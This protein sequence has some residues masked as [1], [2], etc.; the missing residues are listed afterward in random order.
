MLIMSCPVPSVVKPPYRASPVTPPDISFL[1]FFTFW[2]PVYYHIDS[3]E[4]TYAYPPSSSEHSA[5]WVSLSTGIGD[6]F[7]WQ[8]LNDLTQKEHDVHH[9]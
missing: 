1:L 6:Q 7:T 8:I 2:E 9:T 3:A 4:S 5:Y